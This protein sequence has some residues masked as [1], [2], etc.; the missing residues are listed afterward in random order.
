MVLYLSHVA[1][2]IWIP[3]QQ[4]CGCKDLL[5]RRPKAGTGPTSLSTRYGLIPSSQASSESRRRRTQDQTIQREIR[6]QDRVRGCIRMR[7]GKKWAVFVI[8]RIY[9]YD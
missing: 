6:R 3:P 2:G 7:R 4:N 9:S 5:L 8:R 1:H